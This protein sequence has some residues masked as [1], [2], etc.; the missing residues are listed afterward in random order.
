[1]Q[2]TLT[3]QVN[4][5]YQY[6]TRLWWMEVVRG[7]LNIILA[8][9]L[10]FFSYFTLRVL[11]YALGIYLLIDG[12]LD[13]Y[14]VATGKRDSRRKF[15]NYL[16]GFASLGL[17]LLCFYSPLTTIFF[18]VAVIAVRILVRGI[19]VIID[20]RR[21]HQKYEGLTWFF[22]SLLVLFGLAIFLTEE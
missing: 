22:G 16:V 14:K 12:V 5:S 15:A 13:I 21:S 7:V 9:F 1:M 18:I 8:L 20:A 17:G 11:I 3:K 10:L 19:R 4:R 6:H 2:Q